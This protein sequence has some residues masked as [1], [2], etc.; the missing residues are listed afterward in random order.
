[1][2][3]FHVFAFVGY[4]CALSVVGFANFVSLQPNQLL[5]CLDILCEIYYYLGQVSKLNKS[6]ESPPTESF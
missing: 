4:L 2:Y 6:L 3:L 5:S 1:M